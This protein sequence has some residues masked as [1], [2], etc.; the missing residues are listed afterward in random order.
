MKAPKGRTRAKY[1]NSAQ[2][3]LGHTIE[4]IPIGKYKGMLL[5]YGNSERTLKGRYTFTSDGNAM[6]WSCRSCEGV[7]KVYPHQSSVSRVTSPS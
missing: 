5:N 6:N 2:L 1:G 4:D 3:Q 7:N